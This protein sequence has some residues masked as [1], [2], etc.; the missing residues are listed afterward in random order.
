MARRATATPTSTRAA[1]PE[2]VWD[3]YAAVSPPPAAPPGALPP[4]LIEEVR[5]AFAEQ[6]TA[7]AAGPAP[8]PGDPE[9][10]ERRAPPEP[11]GAPFAAELDVCEL[12]ERERPGLTWAARARELS[13]S[14]LVFRSRRMC[15]VDRLLLVAVHLIDAIPAPLYG[16]VILC[17]Y[18]GEGEYEVR[19]SLLPVPQRPEVQ[20]WLESR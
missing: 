6:G 12:D 17:S 8:A 2:S 18:E 9:Q 3:A 4:F 19:L 16:Q 13:R 7:A 10:A 11:K 20:A 14:M 15:Y 1:D 5:A